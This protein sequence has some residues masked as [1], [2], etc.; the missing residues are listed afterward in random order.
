MIVKIIGL[1]LLSLVWSTTVIA[2]D[3]GAGG[4]GGKGGYPLFSS[5]N[6]N[7]GDGLPGHDGKPGMSGCPGGTQPSADGKFYLPG[8]KQLCNPAHA[9]SKKKFIEI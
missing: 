7:G 9:R 3:G 1:S 2:G 8:T 4:K 6:Q 5:G